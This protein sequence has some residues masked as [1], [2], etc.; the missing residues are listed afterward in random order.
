MSF[1]STYSFLLHIIQELIEAFDAIDNGISAYPSTEKP[2]YRM[3]NVSIF[4]KIS[5][6]N[7]Q[8]NEPNIDPDVRVADYI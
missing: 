5:R 3:S 4:S 1:T 7:P 2:T 6:L 8:W